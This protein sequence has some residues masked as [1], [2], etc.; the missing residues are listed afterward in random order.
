MRQCNISPFRET[1]TPAFLEAMSRHADSL[2]TSVAQFELALIKVKQGDTGFYVIPWNHGEPLAILNGLAKDVPFDYS[3]REGGFK[4]LI[5]RD[6]PSQFQVI[7]V[8]EDVVV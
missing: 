3:A 7:S 8:T 6:L 4:I 1:Q 5:S 2:V